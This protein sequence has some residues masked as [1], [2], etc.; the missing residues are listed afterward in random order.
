MKIRGVFFDIGDTLIHIDP[1]VGVIYARVCREKGIPAEGEALERSFR[2]VWERYSKLVLPGVNR[3]SCFPGGEEEWWGRLVRDVLM[4][5][6]IPE[7]S[8]EWYGEFV[9]AFRRPGAWKKYPDVMPTLRKLRE[10]GLVVGAVSNWDSQL[11][12]ILALVGLEDAFDPLVVSGVENCEKPSPV[13]FHAA[14]ERA[15]LQAGET[16]YVG[17]RPEEDFRGARAAG[18]RSLLIARKKLDDADGMVVI[19][20]LDEIFNHLGN[21]ERH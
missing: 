6:G 13:I 7:K 9:E 1:S 14:L 11:P 8:G 5:T 2:S 10:A 21:G 15:G 3:F 12:A 16:I 20:G 19:R 18:L 17:N 4:E